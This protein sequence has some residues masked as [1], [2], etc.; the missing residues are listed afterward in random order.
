M[1][2]RFALSLGLLLAPALLPAQLRQPKQLVT[3]L[4]TSTVAATVTVPALSFHGP[5]GGAS[6][7]L[8]YSRANIGAGGSY[9]DLIGPTS[10]SLA[11]SVIV[12]ATG[13]L[14]NGSYS[15][16]F[17]F[18]N[19]GAATQLAVTGPT[20]TTLTTCSL[21]AVPGYNNVQSCAVSL[22]ITNGSLLISIQPTSGVSMTFKQVTVT[23]YQ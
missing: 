2:P 13:A 10:N 19:V 7:D 21:N 11:G 12:S 8:A 14:P 15:V 1:R 20:G 16:R 23:R 4:L 5:L 18:V 17:D 6:I 9:L 3:P 22:S